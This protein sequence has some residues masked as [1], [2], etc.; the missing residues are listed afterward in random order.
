MGRIDNIKELNANNILVFDDFMTPAECNTI[1]FELDGNL[2]QHSRVVSHT[3]ENA[4][5]E[6]YSDCRS[7]TTMFEYLFPMGVKQ[8]VNEVQQKI[9]HKIGSDERKLEEWQITRYGYAD[10]FEPHIDG[11][12]LENAPGGERDKTI[13]LYLMSPTKGGETYF[14]ALHLY[15]RPIQGRL[16]VWDNLLP[17]GDC[18]HA[19]L[20]AG[21]PVKKGIKV[22]LNTW[23]R[24]F[25]LK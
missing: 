11:G 22:I 1:L 6:F 8:V 23:I 15:V 19:M 18:N 5:S 16:V 7:S 17:N 13:I 10:K 24:Q 12:F 21:L 25:P 2:F 3:A 9:V 20:H 4:Y 14:R